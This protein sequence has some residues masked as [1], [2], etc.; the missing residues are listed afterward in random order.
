MLAPVNVTG[1]S[2]AP[3]ILKLIET[4]PAWVDTSIPSA[5]AVVLATL[6]VDAPLCLFKVNDA[7]VPPSAHKS[8]TL[9][10]VYVVL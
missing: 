6:N 3:L 5:N 1:R 4:L 2:E 9:G 8:P 7:V 10:V